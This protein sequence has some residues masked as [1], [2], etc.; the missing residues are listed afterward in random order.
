[1]P[2]AL[3][4]FLRACSFPV[5]LAEGT[6]LIEAE[7][8]LVFS[9]TEAASRTGCPVIQSLTPRGLALARRTFTGGSASER[10]TDRFGAQADPTF[11]LSTRDNA[12]L[13]R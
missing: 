2:M 7:F 13:Q 5:Y 9:G 11:R 10:S 4:S 12:D 1:M 8:R 3:L 6:G